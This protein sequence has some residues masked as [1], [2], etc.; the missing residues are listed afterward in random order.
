M[1]N[2]VVKTSSLIP[3]Q[4]PEYI[5]EDPNYENFVTFLQSYY[6]WLEQQDNVLDKSKNILNYKDVDRTSDEFINYYI[7]NFLQNFPEDIL[8]DKSKAVKLAKEL[9]QSKGSPS[10]FKLLFKILYNSDFEYYLTRDSV[11]RASDGIWY[12]PKSI[13]INS[14]DPNF[15]NIDN[16][17]LIGETSKT[18]ATVENS[19][20]A[21]TKTEIFISNISRLFQSGEFI[22]VVDNNNQDVLFGGQTLRGK[23]VGQIS[24]ITIDPKNRGLLYDV[25][26]P[27]IVY[28]GLSSANGIGAIAQVGSVTSGSIQN[29]ILLAGGYGY[30]EFPNSIISISNSPTANAVI[31]SLD[32][33][34]NSIAN[35]TLFAIDTLNTVRSIGTGL[36]KNVTIGSSQYYLPTNPTSN[37]NTTLKEALS[38]STFYSYPISSIVLLNGGGGLKSVPQVTA[39]ARV[40]DNSSDSAN[41]YAYIKNIGILSPIKILNGGSGY[42]INDT[43]TF[44]DGSGYGAYANVI[45]VSSSGSITEVSYV[46]G[47]NSYPLGGMGYRSTSLPRLSVSS[48]NV[49]ASNASLIVT[50]I[51]GDG[52]TFDTVIDKIGSVGA[53]TVID[54][55]Q[56]Y[57]FNPSVSLK[58]QDIVVSNV[59]LFNLPQKGDT[60]YQ[61]DSISLSSYTATVD[62]IS[63]LQG[64]LDE[65]QSLYNLRVF[66]YSSKYK[67]QKPLTA[68]GVIHVAN[69]DTINMVMAN[70][71]YNSKYN[72]NGIRTYGD[73]KAKAN[74]SFLN[75][76]VISEGMYINEQGQP[77]SFSVLQN[78]IYNNFTYQIT[79]EKEIEK[80]RNI[81]LNLLHPTGMRVI[82]R[83]AMRSNTHQFETHIT[84]SLYNGIPLDHYTGYTASGIEM[85]SDFDNMS[86]NIITFKDLAGANIADFIF[87]NSSLIQITS[88]MGPNVRSEVLSVD[89]TSNTIS[90]RD[91]V[92]LTF[93]NVAIATA[94]ANSNVINII[95]V[96][97][98]YDIINGGNYSNTMYPM[99]DIVY[100]GD[101]I[102][103]ANNSDKT[104]ESV[105]YIGGRIYLTSNLSSNANSYLSVNRTLDVVD[106][107]V[108]IYG[109][110][111]L[112]YTPELTTEDGLSLTTEDGK[113]IILG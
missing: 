93:A 68:N 73:G 2:T 9:Y 55:G 28:D 18:I 52:A 103:I 59:S 56:D 29:I 76:L 100:A 44:S 15:L 65:T 10:S 74:A 51:L 21:G 38:F 91:N 62:S 33:S 4:L 17:R 1:I 70:V 37:V 66:N 14:A 5:R 71:A 81:L 13:K 75:G 26:D 95:S 104:V 32:P 53:I 45:N 42:E 79:V 43:I 22:R 60:V 6:E 107:G 105:D 72:E 47:T 113:I 80:Y 23:I 64:N 97:N 96:T 25:G 67:D 82:G 109:P 84:E 39:V 108:I 86:N 83:Y 89:G 87:A 24:K 98:S 36:I 35:V 112:E 99:M 31:N 110:V 8:I 20:L 63:L 7:N 30:T 40:S 34:A 69:N 85:I 92:W 50:G 19:V 3:S 12:I 46:S 58:V 101:N 54:P 61:G 78:D 27:V 77:S 48:S 106:G 88:S 57:S 94:N 111:G 11:F 41:A 90:I 16:Y 49:Q 102:K